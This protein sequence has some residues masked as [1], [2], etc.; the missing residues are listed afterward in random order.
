[1]KAVLGTVVAV[2]VT[3]VS[4]RGKKAAAREEEI[5]LIFNRAVAWRTLGGRFSDGNA[6][7]CE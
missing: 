7:V 2:G 1:M 4:V 6:Q 5:V 3:G